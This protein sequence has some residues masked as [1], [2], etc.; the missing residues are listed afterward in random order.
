MLI[1][2]PTS[3]NVREW[4]TKSL[5]TR[6]VIPQSIIS[7]VVTH[8]YDGAYEALKTK[9]SIEL[10]GFGKFFYNEKRAIKEMD[11]LLAKKKATLEVLLDESISEK[12]RHTYEKRLNTIENNILFLKN[13]EDE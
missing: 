3:M 12:K 9:N 2:K 6:E 8:Q 7:A 11:K 5:S 10:A 4:L 1:N 13:R